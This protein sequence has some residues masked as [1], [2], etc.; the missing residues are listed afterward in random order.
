MRLG[1]SRPIPA[2]LLRRPADLTAT[3]SLDIVATGTGS[4]TATAALSINATATPST[5][6]TA[7]LSINATHFALPWPEDFSGGDWSRW[8]ASSVFTTGNVANALSV[9]G[10]A[11]VLS[12]DRV[13]SDGGARA[14]PST[15]LDRVASITDQGV[16]LTITPNSA[17]TNNDRLSVVLRG[18]GTWGAKNNSNTAPRPGTGYRLEFNNGN[19]GLLRVDSAAGAT[20][21]SLSTTS[22]GSPIFGITAG[23]PFKLRFEAIGARLQY[24]M[25][26]VGDAEPTDSWE[27]TTTDNFIATSGIFG[28]SA[29]FFTA[30]ATYTFDDISWYVPAGV[31]PGA[32]TGTAAMALSAAAAAKAPATATA[33]L[34][35]TATATATASLTFAATAAPAAPATATAALTVTAGTVTAKAAGT[36][37]AALS[38]TATATPQAPATATATLAVAAT[39]TAKAPASG[40]SATLDIAATGTGK[41]PAGGSGQLTIAASAVVGGLPATG[42]AALAIAAGG[43]GKAPATASA[44]LTIAA[45]LAAATRAATLAALT[46]NAGTTAGATTSAQANLDLAAALTAAARA[47]TLAALTIAAVATPATH[48]GY[49]KVWAGSEWLT[50]PARVWTGTAW[51]QKPVKV[52]TGTAWKTTT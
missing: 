2:L 9:V 27:Q 1:R 35:F 28:L 17:I 13:G 47:A 39:G 36:A 4:T 41:A 21:A 43:T 18:N 32:A 10:G 16:T 49:V 52:W 45:T 20:E 6:A 7:A 3:A 38:V 34:S 22:V 15:A 42:T 30:T 25:W 12:T 48:G 29:Y 51:P 44:A 33:A 46:I 19:F 8:T 24:R 26:L 50:K 23:V 5:T 31:A 37:T 11:G 40:L 14:Y